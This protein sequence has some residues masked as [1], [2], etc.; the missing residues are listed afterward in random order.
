[1]KTDWPAVDS[2]E[3]RNATRVVGAES[4]SAPLAHA[5]LY[6]PTDNII[7][8]AAAELRVLTMSVSLPVFEQ[9]LPDDGSWI[10]SRSHRVADPTYCVGSPVFDGRSDV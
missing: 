10:C 1:V 7:V 9:S 3:S 2:C 4:G 8:M 6:S 5:W